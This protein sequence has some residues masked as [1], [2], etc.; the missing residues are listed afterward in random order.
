MGG[1]GWHCRR[2]TTVAINEETSANV[3][4][5]N[6]LHCWSKIQI[7]LRPRVRKLIFERKMPAPVGARR[8]DRPGGGRRRLRLR[9]ARRRRH[10]DG[11]TDH[12]DDGR[13]DVRR[14]QYW[15]SR[16]SLTDYRDRCLLGIAT[17]YHAQSHRRRRRRR[18]GNVSYWP[19]RLV[20]RRS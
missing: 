12:V 17:F 14:E 3:Y 18:A 1:F 15:I 10:A 2:C 8:G 11:R 6:I 9:G 16:P 4:C 19:G 5:W 20:I 13:R 7:L